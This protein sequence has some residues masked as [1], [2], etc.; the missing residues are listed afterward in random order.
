M[1]LGTRKQVTKIG[2]NLNCSEGVLLVV[3]F[4]FLDASPATRAA[5]Y[6]YVYGMKHIGLPFL[7]MTFVLMRPILDQVLVLRYS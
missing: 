2:R 3:S 5:T 1:Y 7:L 6:G 4:S